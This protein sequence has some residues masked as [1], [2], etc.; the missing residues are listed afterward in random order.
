[1]ERDTREINT[2]QH[3]ASVSACNVHARLEQNRREVR[4]MPSWQKWNQQRPATDAARVTIRLLRADRND[5][6]SVL[7]VVFTTMDSRI[8][9]GAHV[10]EWQP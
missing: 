8:A 4:E 6:R 2:A 10:R 7:N 1:V 9:E 3:Q 5:Q